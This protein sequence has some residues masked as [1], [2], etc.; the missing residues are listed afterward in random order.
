MTHAGCSRTGC[1]VAL[2]GTGRCLEGF[3]PVDTCPYYSSDEV[4]AE[5]AITLLSGDI[6]DL[7]SGEALNEK[8]AADVAREDT[9]KVIIIA[10]PF[11]SGK[12]TIITSLF[13]AF[14]DAPLSNYLF[15]GS[16]TLV[17]LE[18]RSHLGR[19]ESGLEE[20]DTSHTS[21]REGVMFLHLAL[22]TF[23]SSKLDT[24]SLLLSDISGE[25][26]RTI[27]DSS[28]AAKQLISLTRADHLC[29]VV[30]GERLVRTSERQIA[31][32][33]SRSILRS[34]IEANVLSRSC[35][36]DI[37]ITKW[38][39]I[40]QALEGPEGK[41]IGEFI[42]GTKDAL[43]AIAR[44]HSARIHEI[45]ARPPKEAKVPFAH[46]LPTLL[47]SWMSKKELLAEAPIYVPQTSNREFGR[48]TEATI[49][50]Q[51]AEEVANVIRF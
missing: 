44:N 9:S 27:R 28:E 2:T 30:D 49:F 31:K 24:G 29:I 14:Q 7:P 25:L 1:P 32:N 16:R 33:D 13:E 36:V 4:T 3:D 18:R 11:N 39:L 26:F 17:G 20:A 48:F 50:T 37:A 15:R 47:R 5:E 45:A 35:V 43:K 41:Q 23:E 34:I 46:G 38:D 22:S 40:V 19:E 21:L 12:T 42:D 10:G 51:K 8:Q 6:V